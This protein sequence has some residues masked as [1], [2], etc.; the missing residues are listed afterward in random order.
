MNKLKIYA[1]LLSIFLIASSCGKFLEPKSENEFVPTSVQDID[2]MLLYET[3]NNARSIATIPFFDLLSDDAAVVRF[4]STENNLLTQVHLASIKALYTWQPDVYKTF[5]DDHLYDEIYDV[6]AGCYARILGCN[7]ALDYIWKVDGTE[8]ER[9]RVMAEAHALRAFY[10]FHLVNCY[11]HPYNYEP[12]SLG[13]P[14]HLESKVSSV[15]IPRNTVSEVYEQ[16]LKDLLEAES[17]YAKVPEENRWKSNMRVSLPFVQL[18]M[19]RVYLYMEEWEKASEYAGKVLND[20]NFRLME[21]A[22]FPQD[23]SYMYFHTYTN[24]EVIWPYGNAAEFRDFVDP[25]MINIALGGKVSFVIASPDLVNKFSSGDVRVSAY[26]IKDPRSSAFKAYGKQAVTGSSNDPDANYKFA[27]SFRL[28]E[29]YLNKSEAE[30]MLFKLGKGENHKQEAVRLVVE[31]RSKR[32]TGS[33]ESDIDQRTPDMLVRSIRDERRRE[34][35]FEDHRW[36]DLRRQGMPAIAHEWKG[37]NSDA[38]VTRYTLKQNDPMYTLQI[39]KEVMLKNSL[40][41]QNEGGPARID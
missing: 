40:L 18:L 3:Y 6:Y 20:N 4:Q 26:L 38:S 19:S 34:L 29:A 35:C 1:P 25:Y 28:S 21:I 24:P 23:G 32:I 10:Y 31:L 30:A 22:E 11:G 15:S 33:S 5:E 39:P 41:V 12:E 27:R 36:F 17:L 13:V 2:E 14:L 16:V 7:A 37:D 9:A 8:A